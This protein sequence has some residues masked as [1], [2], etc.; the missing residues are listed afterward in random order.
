MKTAALVAALALTSGAVIATR[1]LAQTLPIDYQIQLQ[2]RA[3]TGGTAF[4]LPNG[5]TF[6]SVSVSLNNTAGSRRR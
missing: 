5:S 4:N 3:A 6:N 2:V 1:A